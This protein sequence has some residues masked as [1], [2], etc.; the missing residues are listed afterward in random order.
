MDDWKLKLRYGQITTPFQH[1]TLIA[2][3]IVGELEDGFECP[4]GTAYMGM[5]TWASDAD[6]A[7]D[8]IKAIG[9]QIGFEVTGKI[10]VFSTDPTE[11][12]GENPHGYDI[13]FTPYVK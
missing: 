6:E 9:A 1:F 3:G 13:Q 11:P 8:M 10:Q 7:A 12:P 5:K 2:D 4:P